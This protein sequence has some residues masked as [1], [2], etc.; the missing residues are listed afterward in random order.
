MEGCKLLYLVKSKNGTI[1]FLCQHIHSFA[2]PEMA[3]REATAPL[4]P[5]LA[6]SCLAAQKKIGGIK[7]GAFL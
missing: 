7:F 3:G 2:F 6:A 1:V 4:N 5:P